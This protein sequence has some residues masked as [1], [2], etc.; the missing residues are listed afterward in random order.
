MDLM[1]YELYQRTEGDQLPN[2]R[3]AFTP[4]TFLPETHS[5][6]LKHVIILLCIQYVLII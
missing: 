4:I 6:M 2:I 1:I 3:G 5:H